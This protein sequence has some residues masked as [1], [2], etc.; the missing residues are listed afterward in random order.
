M[1]NRYSLAAA[2]WTNSRGSVSA[3]S[4]PLSAPRRRGVDTARDLG[5][6]Q[7]GDHVNQLVDAHRLGDVELEPG[8]Q[9]AGAMRGAVVRGEGRRRRGAAALRRQRAHLP[10]QPVAALARHREVAEQ[11]GGPLAL[12][13][14][15]RLFGGFDRGHHGAVLLE[16]IGH[17]VAHEGRIVDNQDPDTVEPRSISHGTPPRL[18]RY[19]GPGRVGIGPWANTAE[20]AGGRGKVPAWA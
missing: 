11:D 18:P 7:R 6:G 2:I 19:R 17:D 10:D 12:Q 13:D 14:V 15:Q 1:P 3:I 5:A 8:A 20:G 16:D 9:D 4:D